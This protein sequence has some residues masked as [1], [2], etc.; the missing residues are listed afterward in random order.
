M[1]EEELKRVEKVVS[2]MFRDMYF[3]GKIALKNRKLIMDLDQTIFKLTE[4]LM[5]E[6]D[7]V[8]VDINLK[9]DE[10]NNKEIKRMY[11]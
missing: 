9:K 4:K 3:L 11:L 6:K 8:K 2:A 7:K 10:K 5:G 1:N